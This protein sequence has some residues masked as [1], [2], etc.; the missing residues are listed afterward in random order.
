MT[1]GGASKSR[2]VE[3]NA[4]VYP[5][6]CCGDS[7]YLK[8]QDTS[9]PRKQVGGAEGGAGW[10]QDSLA[11]PHRAGGEASSSSSPGHS[12]GKA[13]REP[14][15]GQQAQ[16]R[17]RDQPGFPFGWAQLQRQLREAE[18]ALAHTLTCCVTLGKS[19]HFSDSRF[20][21]L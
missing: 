1:W 17:C 9:K 3:S 12:P 2:S 6:G 4:P 18:R 8:R 15:L 10:L 16:D 13:G 21:V 19:L 5:R 7:Q 14:M 20:P 11:E